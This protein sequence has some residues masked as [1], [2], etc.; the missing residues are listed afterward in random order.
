[1]NL[2]ILI[3]LCA[4]LALPAFCC[5][6]AGGLLR[7]VGIIAVI[8]WAYLLWLVADEGLNCRSCDDD[9]NP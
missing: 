5:V 4:A 3:L 6:A 1:M 2:F 7:A 8:G 9:E